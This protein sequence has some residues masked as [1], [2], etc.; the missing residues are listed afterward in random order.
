MTTPKCPQSSPSPSNCQRAA[1]K[2]IRG[3]EEGEQEGTGRSS[4]GS[5]GRSIVTVLPVVVIVVVEGGGGVP[6]IA[7]VT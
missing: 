2:S 4:S 5:G 1:C 3:D 7:V 6:V